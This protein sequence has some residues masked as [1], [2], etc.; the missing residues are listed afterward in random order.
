MII[1][2]AQQSVGWKLEC[3]KHIHQYFFVFPQFFG[4]RLRCWMNDSWMIKH[5]IKIYK[6]KQQPSPKKRAFPDAI[7]H[8]AI[9]SGAENEWARRDLFEFLCSIPAHNNNSRVPCVS[10]KLSF[11]AQRRRHLES[12]FAPRAPLK[13][14]CTLLFS[15]LV[16]C[17]CIFFTAAAIVQ[18]S[19]LGLVF[20]W[21]RMQLVLFTCARWV[22]V[23][24]G[25]KFICARGGGEAEDQV[26]CSRGLLL[27]LRAGI[28]LSYLPLTPAIWRE[29]R[30]GKYALRAGFLMHTVW[31]MDGRI[32]PRLPRP[33]QRG[34]CNAKG[35]K[36]LYASYHH[37]LL[38]ICI[39]VE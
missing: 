28:Q 20:C 31:W 22:I 2:S 39:S 13:R 30:P 27:L 4:L 25:A 29:S 32:K 34:A 26:S 18:P 16:L 6:K 7:F 3:E 19:Q 14:R 12:I 37:V 15:V 21:A 35:Q 11:Q 1:S 24:F 9:I 38:F 36:S 10:N 17:V 23:C 8:P 33:A 5:I